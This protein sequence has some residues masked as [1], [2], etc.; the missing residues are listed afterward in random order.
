M[1]FRSEMSGYKMGIFPLNMLVLSI[2]G[3]CPIRLG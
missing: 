1:S 3:V 2:L